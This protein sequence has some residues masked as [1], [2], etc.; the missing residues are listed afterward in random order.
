MKNQLDPIDILL[1]EHEETLEHLM[2]LNAAAELIKANGFTFDAFQ[3]IEKAFHFIDNE[4][5]HHNEKEERYLFPILEH[6]VKGTPE[7]MRNEHRELWKALNNFS[8]HI[9]DVEES[10]IY[11]NTVRELLY[12]CASIAEQLTKHI[13]KENDML[14]LIA[15]QVLTKEEYE[16]LRQ[17]IADATP[18]PS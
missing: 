14:Y 11:P 6:H 5:R 7:V 3:N 18:I 15:K 1:K 13:T 10:R 9:K 16:Q 2:Q 4:V 12:N 8:A 17:D